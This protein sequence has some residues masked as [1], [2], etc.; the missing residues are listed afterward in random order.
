MKNKKVYASPDVKGIYVLQSI[1]Y[2]GRLCPDDYVTKQELKVRKEEEEKL[3]ALELVKEEAYKRGRLDAERDF[4]LEMEEIKNEYASLIALF[5]DAV[6]QLKEKSE[7]IWQESESE[8]V[9]LVLTISRKMV[10]DDIINNSKDVIK[11]VVKEVVSHISGKKIVAVRLSPDDAKKMDTREEMEIGDQNVKIV[12]DSMVA[13][14]GC[15][16]ETD[17]G[18]IDSQIETRWEEIKK[19]LL[20]N[21]NES[22]V[23]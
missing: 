10:G 20:G 14:G 13:S 19:A 3:K 22:T 17:F 11:H 23:H 1:K 6:N 16:V 9:K 12:E 8:I 4:K 5:Q 2:Q 21:N 15:I 7:K 18:N